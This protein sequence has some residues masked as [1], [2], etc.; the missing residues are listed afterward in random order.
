MKQQSSDQH[1]GQAHRREAHVQADGIV[2][3]QRVGRGAAAL[4]A[5]QR[6]MLQP[7]VVQRSAKRGERKMEGNK[8]SEKTG[9]DGAENEGSKERALRQRGCEWTDTLR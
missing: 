7:G 4:E 1:P 3:S 5:H 2:P 6:L 9:R 8:K